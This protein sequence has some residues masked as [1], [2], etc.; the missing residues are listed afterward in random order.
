MVKKFAL[1]IIV[2]AAILLSACESNQGTPLPPTPKKGG[3]AQASATVD[4]AMVQME[5]FGTQTAEALAGTP[6]GDGLPPLEDGTPTTTTGGLEQ[7]TLDPNFPTPTGDIQMLATV[8]PQ[9]IAQPT[10]QT[11]RPSTY[12]LQQG[13]FIFCLARRFDVDVEQTLALNGLYDSETIQPGLVV[14]IPSGGHFDGTRALRPHPATYTVRA[15]DTIYSIACLYGDVD[16]LN[17]AAVNGLAAPYNLTV[18]AQLNI[19]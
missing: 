19:P 11:A 18:G 7:P 5:I 6:S 15:T 12:V 14:K 17:I 4:D 10:V 13:E 16:P 1:I 3:K 2:L 9:V 8:T